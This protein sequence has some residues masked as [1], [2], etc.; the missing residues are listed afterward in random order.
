[1]ITSTK[2]RLSAPS[3]S[4]ITHPR[5]PP[6]PDTHPST[7]L[8]LHLP[9][10]PPHYLKAQVPTG[11]TRPLSRRL[12][13]YLDPCPPPSPPRLSGSPYPNL[14]SGASPVPASRTTQR[15]RRR[16]RTS[17]LPSPAGQRRR[18]S[19]VSAGTQVLRPPGPTLNFLRREKPDEGGRSASSPSLR[20]SANR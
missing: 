16:E 4:P 15:Q 1:M 2:T 3:D 7:A 5:S 17:P 19:T 9:A 11:T 12:H 8:G 18:A 20:E 14:G 6:N 13:R 10:P